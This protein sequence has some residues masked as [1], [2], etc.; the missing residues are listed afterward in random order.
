M[1]LLYHIPGLYHSLQ[2]SVLA[3]MADAP[4]YAPVLTEG[5]AQNKAGHAK[6]AWLPGI[7]VLKE[8]IQAAEGLFPVIIV[9]IDDGKRLFDR[10]FTA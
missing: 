3:H 9:C 10:F 5:V 1:G 2:I 6:C 7:I 4:G 8:G